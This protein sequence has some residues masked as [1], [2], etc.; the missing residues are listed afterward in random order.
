MNAIRSG[1][2]P[3]RRDESL[4]D[5]WNDLA[6]RAV[7]LVQVV[8]GLAGAA[9]VAAFSAVEARWICGPLLLL[10]A[11]SF[12]VSSI[13]IQAEVSAMTPALSALRGARFVVNGVSI[14]VAVAT[15][16]SLLWLVFG[17]SVGSMR[18]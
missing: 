15:A 3:R 12:G 9:G 10:L 13:L 1:H 17:G 16:I 5:V 8:A 18:V 6:L 2:S 7:P 4:G 11:G 14:A